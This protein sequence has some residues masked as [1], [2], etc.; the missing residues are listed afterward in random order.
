MLNLVNKQFFKRNNQ[1]CLDIIL[2]RIIKYE[3]LGIASFL[4]IDLYK[5]TKCTATPAR[6]LLN[7]FSLFR[8]DQKRLNINPNGPPPPPIWCGGVT[9][10]PPLI[11]RCPKRGKA[12][13]AER[14]KRGS[15]TR[16]K[17]LF[18]YLSR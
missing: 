4:I 13:K 12:K 5:K 1:K 16:N 8:N 15:P 7:R 18:L 10:P 14:I 2:S 3:N 17:N 11:F 6:V 9:P